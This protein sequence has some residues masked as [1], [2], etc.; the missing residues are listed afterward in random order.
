MENIIIIDQRNITSYKIS[1][2]GLA[3]LQ[4]I[5]KI[6]FTFWPF[7]SCAKKSESDF[8]QTFWRNFEFKK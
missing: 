6:S 8:C 5:I 3:K 4:K 1:E 7:Q 2:F